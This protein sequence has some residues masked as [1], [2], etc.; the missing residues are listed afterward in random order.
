VDLGQDGWAGYFN[1]FT[2]QQVATDNLRN[3]LDDSHPIL[4]SDPGSLVAQ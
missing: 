1:A 4:D 3:P 2:Q